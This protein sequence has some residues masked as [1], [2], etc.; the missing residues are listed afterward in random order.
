VAVVAS[1]VVV[2]VTLRVVAPP[3]EETLIQLSRCWSIY[4]L[5]DGEYPVESHVNFSQVCYLAKIRSMARLADSL[6]SPPSE[7]LAWSVF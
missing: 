4:R 7:S 2:V 1:P 5:N 3:G 6:T